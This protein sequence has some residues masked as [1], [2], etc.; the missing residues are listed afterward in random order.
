MVIELVLADTTLLLF[1]SIIRMT[2]QIVSSMLDD[3]LF[4]LICESQ[5]GANE[6]ICLFGSCE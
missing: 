2:I 4:D 3:I 5:G 6:G 1:V